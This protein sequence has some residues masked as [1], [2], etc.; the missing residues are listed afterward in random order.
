VEKGERGTGE[1]KR[2]MGERRIP[3]YGSGDLVT[4]KDK[5]SEKWV[6]RNG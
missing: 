4:G 2:Q 3:I 6:V 1:G 5:R